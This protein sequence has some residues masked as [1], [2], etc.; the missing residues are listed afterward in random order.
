MQLT[1]LVIYNKEWNTAQDGSGT[2]YQDEELVTDLAAP[3]GS[4][5]LYA[6]K[7]YKEYYKQNKKT[8]PTAKE[9]PSNVITIT[10]PNGTV[11][12]YPKAK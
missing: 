5:T 9:Q 10:Y 2:S 3:A 12:K 11:K 7:H 8:I 4:I 6:K 1:I